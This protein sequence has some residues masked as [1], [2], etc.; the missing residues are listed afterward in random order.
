MR[1]KIWICERCGK[2]DLS[3]YFDYCPFCGAKKPAK[4]RRL[5][6]ELRKL[7]KNWS[8]N[9]GYVSEF[10]SE[11]SDFLSEG[12][13]EFIGKVYVEWVELPQHKKFTD[14][15]KELL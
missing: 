5:A 7:D 4:K 1:T 11:Y 3:Y 12:L 8:H 13:V 10:S 9:H 6:D 14:Y 2:D 15:L